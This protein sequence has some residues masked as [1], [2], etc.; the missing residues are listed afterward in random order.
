V[1][2]EEVRPSG[3]RAGRY[4]VDIQRVDELLAALHNYSHGR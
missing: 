1:V 3:R 2:V 4:N